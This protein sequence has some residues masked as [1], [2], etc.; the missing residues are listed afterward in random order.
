[1]STNSAE[2]P[3]QVEVVLLKA[4]RTKIRYEAEVLGD[5]GTRI[6]IRAPWAGNGTRD[7]GF[8][9]FEPGDVF[10]EYYWRDRWYAVKEVR[11]AAGALKGWYCDI[12]PT[13]WRHWPEGAVSGRC[14]RSHVR[15]TRS[16]RS[17]VRLRGGRSAAPARLR[18]DRRTAPVRLTLTPSPPPHTARRPRPSPTAARRPTAGPRVRARRAGRGGR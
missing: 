11:D 12:T 3:R 7:F 13:S 8:V 15:L 5:D 6:A 16:P 14:S 17:P 10:T 9:R 18:G 2:W 4:G 1:M